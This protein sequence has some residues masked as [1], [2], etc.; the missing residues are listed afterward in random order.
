MYSLST[1]L[2]FS[3]NKRTFLKEAGWCKTEQDTDGKT[4]TS[5]ANCTS[6]HSTLHCGQHPRRRWVGTGK[7]STENENIWT[8]LKSHPLQG[9][10]MLTDPRP[11]PLQRGASLVLSRNSVEISSL[12]YNRVKVPLTQQ[13]CR[14]NSCTESGRNWDHLLPHMKM[15]GAQ[16]LKR[17]DSSHEAAVFCRR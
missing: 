8:S 14:S 9:H 10:K 3:C 5:V 1:N 17:K 16:T 6:L 12:P 13:L 2:C 7:K 11:N 4:G 15:Q